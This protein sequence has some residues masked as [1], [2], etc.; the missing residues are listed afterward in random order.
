MPFHVGRLSTLFI[1]HSI[2]IEYASEICPPAKSH[3]TLY[4]AEHFSGCQD[5]SFLA[6]FNE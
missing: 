4:K 6:L 2:R 3:R 1:W 5:I